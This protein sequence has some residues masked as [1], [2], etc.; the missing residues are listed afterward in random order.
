[1]KKELVEKAKLVQYKKTKG[2][3]LED[4]ESKAREFE[5]MSNINLPKMVGMLEYKEKQISN[6][7]SKDKMN[8]AHLT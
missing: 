2:K 1:M 3:R 6:L 5:V 8:E 4:L 7:L